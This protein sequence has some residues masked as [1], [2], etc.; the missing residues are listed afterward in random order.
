MIAFELKFQLE[1]QASVCDFGEKLADR[2]KFRRLRT[3]FRRI[4]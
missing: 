4:S 3:H 1:I 2:I